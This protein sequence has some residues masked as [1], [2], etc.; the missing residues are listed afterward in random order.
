MLEQERMHS[1]AVAGDRDWKRER[2]E[3]ERALEALQQPIKEAGIPVLLV[4]EGWS[5]SGKGSVIARTIARL[6]PRN[7]QVFAY[8]PATDEEKRR[9]LLWP[10]WKGLPAKG[11][12]AVLERSWLGRALERMEEAPEETGALVEELNIF[13]RQLCDDGYLLLKFFLH[14]G[15]AEQRRRLEELAGDDDTAWRVTD[16]DWRQNRD[17]VRRKEKLDLLLQA[18]STPHA[19]WH[20]VWNEEKGSGVLEVLRTVKEALA[21]ALVRGVPRPAPAERAPW[22]LLDMPRLDQVDLSPKVSEDDYDAA[23]KKEKKRLAKLHSR[24]YREKVPVVI[25]FEG[26]DAAGKGGAIRRLSW[27]LDPRGFDVVPIAAP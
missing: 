25:G 13:E 23:L 3:L 26:W 27:A 1:R 17:Y 19:P 11:Q 24:L 7:Y 15:Q 14:I 2:K 8:G 20:V 21:D 22:P 4:F 9:P 5:A 6:D 18:A 16:R 12:L 10:F